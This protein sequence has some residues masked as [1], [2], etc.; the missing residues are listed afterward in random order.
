M[1]PPP[2]PGAPRWVRWF[3]VLVAVVVMAVVVLHL[4]GHAPMSHG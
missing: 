1:A 4:T 3:G 2:Y